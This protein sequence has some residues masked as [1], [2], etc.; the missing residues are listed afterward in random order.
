MLKHV[1][2]IKPLLQL[3][4]FLPT[5]VTSSNVCQ[6][7]PMVIVTMLILP[8]PLLILPLLVLPRTIRPTNLL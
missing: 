4:A 2:P 8:L 6:F 5:Y 7:F 1:R 3:L